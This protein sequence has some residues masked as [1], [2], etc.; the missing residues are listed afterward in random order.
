MTADRFVDLRKESEVVAEVR[1]ACNHAELPQ[2]SDIE[3]SLVPLL[4]GAPSI[5]ANLRVRRNSDVA[6][7]SFHARLLFDEPVAGP[8]V[9]GNLRRYGLGLFAPDKSHG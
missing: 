5:R 7:P 2:P 8:I 9:L 6:M 4:E 3:V 1:R